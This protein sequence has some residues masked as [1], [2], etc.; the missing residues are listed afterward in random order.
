MK[1]QN[2]PVPMSPSDVDTYMEPLLRAAASGDL[3]LVK[4][5]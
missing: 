3:S 5:M 2:M 4:A 1:L